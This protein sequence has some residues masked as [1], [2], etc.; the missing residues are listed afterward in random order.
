MTEESK[1]SLPKLQK[2]IL[3]TLGLIIGMGVLNL[4]GM[5]GFYFG[6]SQQ[7][8]GSTPASE[9]TLS[10]SLKVSPFPTQE[11]T[12]GLEIIS[13]PGATVAPTS[14]PVT[15]PTSTPL[16]PMKPSETKTLT[17]TA[18]LDGFRASDG[19]GK[20]SIDIRAG[21]N[22]S[23]VQ[24]GFVS[25]NLSGLPSGITLEKATLR[26]Y[27]AKIV[28]GPYGVAGNLKVDHLDYGAGLEADDYD[29]SP[30]LVDIGTLAT[31]PA[32]EWK[33]LEV[34][35]AVTDDL[36]RGRTRSQYRLYFATETRGGG[37]TG[38]FA[39]FESGENY[40]STGNIPQLV[41]VFRRT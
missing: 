24:R 14:S 33:T 29:R 20:A 12:L 4:V 8:V 13:T 5:F 31:N 41:V 18:S 22:D 2:P 32:L 39:Y 19:G 40:F 36:N 6:K 1:S 7:Q 3:I 10:S 35:E 30:L 15:S 23:L 16:A 38:D 34:T 11:S 26:L 27:Q 25:F 28:G 21:R 17:S 37:S 9:G